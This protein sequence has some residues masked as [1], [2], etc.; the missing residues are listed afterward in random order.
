[1]S[2][3]L[4]LHPIFKK[5]ETELG[6]P[7][8]P[9]RLDAVESALSD[10]AGNAV[11]IP[12]REATIEELARAHSP[13]YIESVL[14]MIRDGARYL[15][16]GD[17]SVC[18]DSGIIARTATGSVLNAVDRVMSGECANAFCAVRPPGH[19]ATASRAMGFCIFNNVAAAARHAQEVHGAARVAILDWDVHHGNG[20]QDIFYDDASVLFCST[21]QSPWYPGTGAASE[22]GE[23]AGEGFT[24]NR[25]FPAGAGRAEILCAFTSDFLPAVADFRPDLILI[26]AGFDSRAGDPLGQFLLTDTDFADLT[27]AVLDTASA[28]C[29]GRVVSVLEGGY[30]L[31]GLGSAVRAHVAVLMAAAEDGARR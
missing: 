21:H 15:A 9:R 28:C 17:V 23:G 6:H 29:G 3:G 12:I 22:T 7:E 18:R 27:R 1:M 16:G 5:H 30:N 4:V 2:T 24:I 13:K 20:T 26:S 8:S 11:P 25:P 31:R 10:V 19:H 14:A